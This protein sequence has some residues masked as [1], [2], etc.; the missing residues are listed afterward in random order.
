MK[1]K[2][3]SARHVKAGRARWMGISAK[4]RR[5]IA[6]KNGKKGAASFW[7]RYKLEKR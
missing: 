3:K 5:E 7:K 4:E 1:K 2:E 6:S